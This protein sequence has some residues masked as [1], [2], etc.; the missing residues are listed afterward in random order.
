MGE[1]K[2]SFTGTGDIDEVGQGT[3]Q[4]IGVKKR[5]TNICGQ[6]FQVDETIP[7]GPASDH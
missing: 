7:Q 3:P 5:F 6:E 4:E 2:D 1:N